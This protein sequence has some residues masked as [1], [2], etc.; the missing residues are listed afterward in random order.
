MPLIFISYASEDD[1]KLGDSVSRGWVT[2]FDEALK[3]ELRGGLKLWRDK[4]DFALPGAIGE[5]LSIEIK[6]SDFLLP[7]LSSFYGEK[8]YT[9]F[10]IAEFFR[11]LGLKALEPT[12]FIIPVM[13]RPVPEDQIPTYL[14]GVRWVAFFETN[15]DGKVVPFFEGFGREISPKY[16][17][18][19]RDVVAMI[20]ARIKAQQG[21]VKPAA[22]VYLA[23]P[24]IDQIDPHW[25]VS[26]ELASKKCR[27]TPKTPWPANAADARSHLSKALS[28]SQFSI[29][30]LGAT[31]GQ[32][33]RSGLTALSAMELDF[34]AERQKQDKAFRRLIWMPAGLEPKDDAQRQLIQSLN[35]G[36]R[37]TESDEFVRGGIESFKEIVL[38]E[39]TRAGQR[40]A[41][42]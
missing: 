38:D 31:P 15:A 1:R 39:L 26:N 2:A 27:V 32:E 19:I 14:S 24:A 4:R 35:E 18:A 8:E 7:V 3:L 20:E 33:R 37:L 29:H 28:E 21:Q 9:R 36:S 22:T 11:S 23:H 10:E 34:A 5:N 25:S 17:G 40:G 42:P 12:D 41:H 30:L 13:P 6:N 16:F